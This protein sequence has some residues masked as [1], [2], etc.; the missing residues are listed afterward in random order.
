MTKE[1]IEAAVKA[2]NAKMDTLKDAPAH[3]DSATAN[4]QDT[5]R[6]N[7]FS[8]SEDQKATR[9][10]FLSLFKHKNPHMFSRATDTRKTIP[11]GWTREQWDTRST[12]G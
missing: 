10:A 6:W 5:A 3:K 4:T 1:Q 11:K 7:I 9:R 12:A 2:N 8:L